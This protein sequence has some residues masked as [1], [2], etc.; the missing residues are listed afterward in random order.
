MRR[1]TSRVCNLGALLLLGTSAAWAQSCSGDEAFLDI[2]FGTVGRGTHA[3]LLGENQVWISPDALYDSEKKY[4]VGEM[5]CG[6]TPYVQ[7]N[8]ELNVQF[9]AASQSLSIKPKTEILDP[10]NISVSADETSLPDQGL[11]STEPLPTLSVDYGLWASTNLDRLPES[12]IRGQLRAQLLYGDWKL[13]AMGNEI[14]TTS[15]TENRLTTGDA[16]AQ[17]EY[18]PNA[19]LNALLGWNV[20]PLATLVDRGAASRSA[21]S[22]ARVTISNDEISRVLPDLEFVLAA[23][24]QVILKIDGQIAQV[25]D[26]LPPGPIHLKNIPLKGLFG[27]IEVEIKDVEGRTET[28]S[29]GYTFNGNLLSQNGYR[30]FTEGGITNTDK[31]G[32][33]GANYAYGLTDDWSVEGQGYWNETR[34]YGMVRAITGTSDQT[35]WLG[36]GFEWTADNTELFFQPAYTLYSDIGA[37]QASLN[38]GINHLENSKASVVFSRSFSPFS[39]ST[40]ATYDWAK[41]AIEANLYS[42]WRIDN[43]FS[44]ATSATLK[45]KAWTLTLSGQWSPETNFFAN[46]TATLDPEGKVKPS[47]SLFYRLDDANQIS[48][49]AS[50]DDIYGVYNFQSSAIDARLEANNHKLVKGSVAGGLSLMNGNVYTTKSS[51]SDVPV[52][53]R[54]GVPDVKLQIDGTTAT[55]SANG[56]V[57]WSGTG[58]RIMQIDIDIESLPITV[59]I[60]RT[61]FRVKSQA[62]RLNVVDLTG[63]LTVSKEIHVLW[64]D[65]TNASFAQLKLKGVTYP[66]DQDGFAL[67]PERDL[68]ETAQLVS[69]DGKQTCTLA[70]NPNADTFVCP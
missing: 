3:T 1:W 23:P 33:A 30:G 45:D 68:I 25:W 10:Q 26:N 6:G 38:L 5:T 65:N 14:L 53:V 9:D 29:K 37:L 60:G 19:N 15:A 55:S 64:K 8:P 40:R 48:L 49:S 13:S 31:K 35:L 67:V 20:S 2:Y 52:L 43:R 61:S 54:L 58:D 42:S 50:L 18:T 69:E 66:L 17:L 34:A 36:T 16:S 27:R 44:V 21:F 4:I 41:K 24:A 56:E 32:Y 57:F 22:G 12:N 11:L 7:L 39:M 62:N 28:L 59:A 63:I 70:L 51:Q 46:A 47:G